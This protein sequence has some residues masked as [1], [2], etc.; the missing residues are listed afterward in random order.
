ME[1]SVD[2]K[3]SDFG[4]GRLGN[5]RYDVWTGYTQ[6]G[7]AIYQTAKGLVGNGQTRSAQTGE[8]RPTG[9]TDVLGQ[10]ARSKFMPS[11]GMAIEYNLTGLTGDK[12]GIG[13][14]FFGEDRNILEDMGKMPLT[15][16]RGVPTIDEES[17]W[18]R[19]LAPL[20]IRDI[21]NAL[22][23][24]LRPLIP[25]SVSGIA[26]QIDTSKE[27]PTLFAVAKSVP[28]TVGATLGLGIT[29]FRTKNDIAYEITKDQ[30]GGAKDYIRMQPFEQDLVDDIAKAREAERGVSR[31]QGL[32][33]TLD[34]IDAREVAFYEDLERRA[35]TMTISEVN[36]E[37]YAGKEQFRVEKDRELYA[38]FGPRSEEFK[39]MNRSQMGPAEL[40]VQEFYDAL[41]SA[42]EVKLNV[43]LTS[44]EYSSILDAWETKMVN[45]GTPVSKAA[46]FMVRM[47][48]HRTEIP[49]GVLI[50]LSA[51]TRAR[52]KAARELR[53]QYRE[54]ELDKH[55]Y[56]N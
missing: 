18:T 8:L 38:E 43:P 33:A 31:T 24:E 41:D 42:K 1:A 56:V 45:T 55:L 36:N 37:Y 40:L 46:L 49:Q 53:D 4:K 12:W 23:E 35:S 11:L 25:E 17:F 5:S 44:D 15:F 2:P 39:E 22:E 26:P 7:R 28:P 52:Y 6:F 54:G 14:G 51:K 20:L 30:P 50:R 34:E 19:F 47:N 9:A 16:I 48:T 10:F 13:T 3:S 29:T 32:G 27:Q 21:S